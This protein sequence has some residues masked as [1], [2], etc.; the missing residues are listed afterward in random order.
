M[1]LFVTVNW[2]LVGLTAFIILIN[3]LKDRSL[4]V[5]PSVMTLLF[6]H[7]MC[8]WGAA[9]E[10]AR[11]EAVLP[12]PWVFVLLSHGFPLLGLLMS[13]LIGR[14]AARRVWARVVNKNEGDETGQMWSALILA[15]SLLAFLLYYFSEVPFRSTGLY[16]IFTAPETAPMARDLSVKFLD[17][18]LL[19][20]GHNMV[21]AA[22]VPLLA[23]LLFQI[24]R[25]LLKSRKWG[26]L[27][28]ALVGLLLLFPVA[29]ISGARSYS[30]T[31]VLVLLA[32][33]LLQKGARISP[34]LPLAALVF[35]LVFPTLLTI[36]REGR[37][38]TLDRFWQYF[39]NNA[40]Q[41]VLV[42]PMETGLMHTA[43]TQTYGT[44]GVR[45]VPRLAHLLGVES[46]DVRNFV[47]KV[48]SSNPKDTTTMN[49]AYV[50]AY[51]SYFGLLA[52]LPCL[53]GLWLLDLSLLL[54]QR[55]STVMLVPCIAAISIATH[56]FSV[57]EYTISLFSFGFLAILL[58]AWASDRMVGRLVGGSGVE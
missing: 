21:M 38:L 43:Y 13:L 34:M 26:K 32:A 58:V 7:I 37:T 48:Y 57:C 19:R 55:L 16:A 31:L 33:W 45:A 39:K 50:Y 54:Y 6:F 4:L 29:S 35:V 36:L 15:L 27:L 14:R 25:I 28:A 49:T 8:Q 46:M 11:V 3:L 2:I 17:N 12:M 5:K 22:L 51:Y 10:A 23:V 41:R 9:L 52:F 47:A 56:S 53:I 30:A 40:Y 20:Y 24:C 18:A 44:F 1:S 42:I